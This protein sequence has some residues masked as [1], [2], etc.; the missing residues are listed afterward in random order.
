MPPLPWRTFLPVDPE[1][2]Y[3]VTITRL[4]LRSHLRIPRIMRATLRI[5]RALGRS[6]GLVGYS[7]KADLTRKTFWTMSAW[8][9]Q[10]A[11]T[12]F[13]R[14]EVHRDAMTSLQPHMDGPVIKTIDRRGAELPMAWPD[15]A[16]ALTAVTSRG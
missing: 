2:A 1:A 13:V 7:L 6:E 10:D 9:D 14:S 8:T 16:E 12:T 5:V 4:P 15:V 3:V 11:L